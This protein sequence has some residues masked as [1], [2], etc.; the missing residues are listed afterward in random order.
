MVYC[1]AAGYAD[2]ETELSPN[3]SE[4]EIIEGSGLTSSPVVVPL[5]K[6]KQRIVPPDAD[7]QL[8][9]E[10][11]DELFN[12]ERWAYR[13]PVFTKIHSL[14]T[15]TVQLQKKI[16]PS[17]PHLP[18]L[19][20]SFAGIPNQRNTQPDSIIAVGGN[21]VMLA[22]NTVVGIYTKTGQQKFLTS[23]EEWFAPLG[24]KTV[25]T[26]F[27]P[28]L[29][30][31]H[32]TGHF[33]FMCNA[34]RSDHRS[35]FLLSV[36]KTADPE[37]EW[38]FW[39]VDMQITG[40]KREIF[41]ADFPRIGLDQNAL[42]L[43]GNMTEFGSLRFRYAKIRVI[44]KSQLYNFGQLNWKEFARMTDSNGLKSINI[45][46]VMAFGDAPAGYLISTTPFLG[47]KLT[48]WTVVR[49][50]SN[51]PALQKRA[52]P[53]STYQL[54]PLAEQR[55]GSFMLNTRD[56]G[57]Y[58]AVYR[59]GFIYTAHN[60][61]HDWGSGPYSAIRLYQISTNGKLVQEITYGKSGFH[62]YYP[63][64]MPDN[65]GNLVVGFN[66]S[67]KSTFA[68]IFFAG[69]RATDPPGKLQGIKTIANGL[70]HYDI[71]FRGSEVGKWGDYNGIAFDTDNSIYVY[72]QYTI[73]TTEW[74]TK[75][76]RISY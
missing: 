17:A 68:G 69:R 11:E 25:G 67:S 31:D 60:T 14:Q 56:A 46:P 7:A 62:Y 23:F 35:W 29:L 63:V 5:S 49:P 33:I 37:G 52:V 40:G 26:L 39:A 2:L 22:V 30:Y 12:R 54:P 3:S 28:K 24:D 55:G 73:S 21:H 13:K 75:V 59:D 15:E 51:N 71:V 10:E 44:R 58:N 20:S 66:R 53:V 48:L 45:E 27:D 57:V 19:R 16:L 70:T 4:Q 36:S 47:E 38:A 43:S 50:G 65:Q 76:A 61:A 34:R 8:H 74:A 32:Y 9:E 1:V 72:S 18:I 42:Y 64:L 6:I 41:W